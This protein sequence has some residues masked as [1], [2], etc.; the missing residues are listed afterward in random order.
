MEQASTRQV[1]VS[2]DKKRARWGAFLVT[3]GPGGR[4]APGGQARAGWASASPCAGS[5]QE[6]LHHVTRLRGPRGP[7][8]GQNPEIPTWAG[9][10]G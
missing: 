10:G 7:T 4:W 3:A 9:G 8:D 5:G 6:G 1:C 2:G